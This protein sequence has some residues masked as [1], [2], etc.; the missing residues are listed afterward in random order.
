MKHRLCSFKKSLSVEDNILV[1]KFIVKSGNN[2]LPSQHHRRLLLLNSTTGLQT[3][4]KRNGIIKN[5]QEKTMTIILVCYQWIDKCIKMM[6]KLVIFDFHWDKYTAEKHSLS[7]KVAS[8]SPLR[9]SIA[10][11]SLLRCLILP[12]Y[13]AK[14]ESIKLLI[15]QRKPY[16]I[17]SITTTEEE[18]KEEKHFQS[19]LF[20]SNDSEQRLS[21]RRLSE[22]SFIRFLPLG[23]LFN[24]RH[25]LFRNMVV[26]TLF[27]QFLHYIRLVCNTQ[28]TT[29]QHKISASYSQFLHLNMS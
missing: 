29:V 24:L 2:I 22:A 28:L 13:C 18:R 5:A 1:K 10:C 20:R 12:K 25:K 16:Q 7:C 3:V 27:S 4:R 21:C 15:S 14:D 26:T 8:N 6:V 9:H 17:T 23:N 11:I 19:P